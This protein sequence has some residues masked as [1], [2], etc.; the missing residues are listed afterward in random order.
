MLLMFL[1]LRL[2]FWN[3]VFGEN[4]GEKCFTFS[5]WLFSS[6]ELKNF[7]RAKSLTFSRTEITYVSPE[8]GI[9]FHNRVF[10]IFLKQV[11]SK[12]MFNPHEKTN[13]RMSPSLLI[14]CKR[15]GE[16]AS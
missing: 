5:S 7:I 9:F 13:P 3:D 12:S 14:F 1:V 10:T 8:V 6:W 2:S 16:G 15:S 11:Q 4:E